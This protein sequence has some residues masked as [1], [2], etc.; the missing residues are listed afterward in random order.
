MS[1]ATDGQAGLENPE[2]PPLTI[3]LGHQ[4]SLSSLL[5]LPQMRSLVGDFPEEFVFLVEEDRPRALSL[6]D[7]LAAPGEA[8]QDWRNIERSVADDCLE[9]YHSAV[10]LY[11]PLFE[12]EGLKSQYDKTMREGLSDSS[13]SA[14][15]LAI[16]ALGI[17]AS[18]PIDPTRLRWSGDE[19][20]KQSLRLLFPSWAATFSG[21]LVLSQALVLCSL[22]FCYVA[23]P[24]MA[25]RLVH[26]ASTSVQQMR[27]EHLSQQ[28]HDG[29]TRVGWT[30]F[31]IEC[32][33]LA[34]FHQPR[35]GIE[36]LVDKMP[37]PTYDDATASESLYS[38]ADISARSLSNRIHHTMYFTDGISLY[39]GR[40]QSSSGTLPGHPDVSLLR[41][42]EELARQLLTW[43]ESL[44]N[45]IRPDLS[46]TYKGSGQACVLRLRYWSAR[47]NIYRPFVIYV[48]S[49]TADQ[50][51][52]VPTSVLERCKLCLAAT[53]M[54][55]LSAGYVLSART[56]YTFSTTQ[57]VVS[58]ALI[59]ALAAQSPI[60]ADSVDDN[61]E[62]LE[63]AVGLLK[64]W[65]VSGSG[66]ECG[67][68]IISSV[69]RKQRL[70]SNRGGQTT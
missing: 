39:M 21:D 31:L 60:L 35:S 2:V 51:A 26:M 47:H 58:Y 20:I 46:G 65:A 9:R 32:D 61:L 6:Q 13:W 43:Y 42:C 41:V 45:A 37:F 5:T 19:L 67:L 68:E 24:L 16:F 52:S 7:I 53:R 28:T 38:L 22:Y 10:H 66:I 8:N 3:P 48:T 4:T 59:L 50:E 17:T 34:E 11:R 1:R 18:D 70:R 23:E 57:C 69:Y 12:W 36:L 62:L 63:T 54:F 56:P 55:I 49:R 29:V 40:S 33:I 14:L 44:P 27:K 30:C 25:W 15:F 64:P